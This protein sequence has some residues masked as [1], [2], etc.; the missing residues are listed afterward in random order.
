MRSPKISMP[1]HGIVI[2]WKSKLPSKGAG[3][4]HQH[5]TQKSRRSGFN[6]SHALPASNTLPPPGTDR[7]FEFRINRPCN[8]CAYLCMVSISRI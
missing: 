7:C 8:L 5:K 2:A 1:N 4:N 3:Q 6:Q